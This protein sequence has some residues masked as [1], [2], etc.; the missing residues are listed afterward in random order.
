MTGYTVVIS[1]SAVKELDGLSPKT[2]ERV[3]DHILQ[4]EDNPHVFGAEKLTG[5]DAYKLRV[6]NLRIIYTIDDKDKVVEIVMVDD[7]KQVY[8]RIRKRK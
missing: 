5:I 3:I 7:R 1:R 6:G 2:H 8:K 4:L